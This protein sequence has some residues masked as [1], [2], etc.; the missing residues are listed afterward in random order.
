MWIWSAGSDWDSVG[1]DSGPPGTEAAGP[2]PAWTVAGTVSDVAPSLGVRVAS[3]GSPV[4]PPVVV[5][6]VADPSVVVRPLG[7][8][9]LGLPPSSSGGADCQRTRTDSG[10]VG[11]AALIATTA[12]SSLDPETARRAS[13]RSNRSARASRGSS[14]PFLSSTSSSSKR[15]S[16]V[17]LPM[18]STSSRLSSA[19]ESPV[20]RRRTLRSCRILRSSISGSSPHSSRMTVRACES[21]QSLG[22]PVASAGPSISSRRCSRAPDVAC[23]LTLIRVPPEVRRRRAAKPAFASPQSAEST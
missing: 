16:S 1:S 21:G 22:A 17:S 5:P 8:A 19:L 7:L 13:S 6:P 14:L 20:S 4:A 23:A 10:M 9:V 12:R 3:P 11:N 15:S 2:S 18:T